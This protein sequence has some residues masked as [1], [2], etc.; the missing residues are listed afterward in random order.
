MGSRDAGSA[1]GFWEAAGRAGHRDGLFPSQ[2]VAA[3][4]LGRRWRSALE[5]AWRIGIDPG[6]AVLELGCG[7]GEFAIE[8]LGPRFR[9][10]DALDKSRAA[11][12]RAGARANR[13][14]VHFR[15]SDL[16]EHEFA[17]GERWDGAF[18]L[19]V[20]HHVKP[21]AASMVARLSRV[22]PRVV[23]IE[24]NGDNV[25]RRLLERLPSSRRAGEGSF[26]LGELVALFER[27]GYELRA[28]RNFNLFVRFM[29]DQLFP[30]MW[31]LE[32][33]VEGTPSLHGFCS[34]WVLGF[35]RDP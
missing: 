8:V 19:G 24:P 27:A 10:V 26:R 28:Q 15:V 11:I 7:D 25:L 13:G 22:V 12:D 14:N 32:R 33:W 18:L 2:R 21:R 34:T 3:H 1:E 17:V 30:L 4:V 20:L 9:R 16:R 29:P 35:G 23:V 5:M 6:G 31:R